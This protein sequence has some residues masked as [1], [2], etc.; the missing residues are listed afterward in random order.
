MNEMKRI[1]CILCIFFTTWCVYAQTYVVTR[2]TGQVSKISPN[3]LQP[4]TVNQRLT[5]MDIVNIGVYSMLDLLDEEGLKKINVKTPGQDTLKKMIGMKGNTVM[6]KSKQ[7]MN[8]VKSNMLN[9]HHVAMSDPATITMKGADMTDSIHQNLVDGGNTTN[10]FDNE[11]ANFRKQV[12]KEYEDFRRQCIEQYTDFIRQTWKEFGGK[13]AERLPDMKDIPPVEYVPNMGGQQNV[14]ALSLPWDTLIVFDGLYSQP[15]PLVRIP[16]VRTALNN[17]LYFTFYGTPNKVRFDP[18][19][20]FKM[21]GVNEDNIAD[22]L[23]ILGSPAFDN[24]IRDC[25]EIRYDMQLSDW[26]YLLMLHAM[27]EQAYGKGT[28]EAVLLTTYIYMQSG[29]KVRLATDSFKIYMLVASRHFIYGKDYYILD[30]ERYFSFEPIPTRLKISEVNYPQEQSLS[31]LM[32]TSPKFAY[33]ATTVRTIQS[34]RYPELSISL[35]SNKNLI[36]FYNSYPASMIDDNFV[37]IWAMY[38]N[39]PLSPDVKKQIYPTL[40][41]ALMGCDEK[42]SVNK[43]L[44]LIQTGLVYEYDETVWGDDRAFFSEETLFYPYCDCEDRSILLARLVRDLLHLKCILVYYPGHLATAVH[45]STPVDGDYIDLDGEHFTIADPTYIGASVGD[46]MP[47]MDN[48]STTVILL[49]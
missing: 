46:T 48:A 4:V 8:Y 39:A 27:S 36:D 32:P 13:P 16:E 42:E 1:F 6:S 3:G 15:M 40:E 5:S 19:I 49:Q 20:V 22:A 28:N 14:K 25:L 34:S 38:A 29:Y 41:Q 30:G 2:V 10:P 44:N 37:T 31:L 18:T 17:Y 21:E 9:Q 23:T 26:A 47:G 11:L 43:L 24:T 35:R 7:Y 45:F 33:E 12:M